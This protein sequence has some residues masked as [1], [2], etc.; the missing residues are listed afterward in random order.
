MTNRSV[1][2]TVS[3]TGIYGIISVLAVSGCALLAVSL[4]D[5][6]L[7][8]AKFDRFFVG[9][10][11]DLQMM[12]AEYRLAIIGGIYVGISGLLWRWRYAF[13]RTVTGEFGRLVAAVR[14]A[15]RAF[16]HESGPHRIA[17]TFVIVGGV[18]LRISYLNM[19]MRLDE[20]RTFIAYVSHPLYIGLSTYYEPN[21]HVF[22]TFLGHLSISLLGNS[23]WGLRVPAFVAGAILLPLAYLF[24][25][26][27]FGKHVGLLC[28][29]L[30]SLSHALIEYSV[31]A[32]GYSILCVITLLAMIVLVCEHCCGKRP[33]F[34]FLSVATALGLYTVPTMVYLVFPLCW[35]SFFSSRF[36]NDPVGWRD[37]Y[38]VAVGYLTLTGILTII[39]YS[40]IFL[41]CGL[42][43]LTANEWVVPLSTPEFV[44]A[45]PLWIE[46][47]W[48]TV[49]WG[50][51]KPISI[52]SLLSCA[53][54]V[55]FMNRQLK[56][57]SLSVTPLIVSLLVL[58][59][60]Q[61][62]TPNPRSLLYLL[63]LYYCLSAAGIYHAIRWIADEPRCNRIVAVVAVSLFIT[64]GIRAITSDDVRHVNR[65]NGMDHVLPH[66]RQ[67]AEDLQAALGSGDYVYSTV[68]RDVVLHYY[69]EVLG[70]FG[71]WYKAGTTFDR[72][73][74]I[75]ES[76]TDLTTELARIGVVQRVDIR[77]LSSDNGTSVYE[78]T[79]FR[80][81]QAR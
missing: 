35:W 60:V 80:E 72:L 24:G 19:P 51:P 5:Q 65:L 3:W 62:V 21:N 29:C 78:V 25:R 2:T 69:L 45:I 6:D 22:H 46:T 13:Q 55:L 9:A 48:V 56:R 54:A 74:V 49:S 47:C 79:A 57:C 26:L 50:F 59:C 70:I 7:A 27:V 14:Q 76:S 4:L 1:V 11:Q 73:F 75:I 33:L 64:L 61:H 10:R 52:L 43:S 71:Y 38:I 18:L 23:E 12:D 36:Q 53:I 8:R 68:P 37:A 42:R 28:L 81:N 39:L 17:V 31:N 44:A 32:R 67:I 63:P 58:V 41:F 40:P 30:V 15:S 77:L 34:V 20:A 66:A 16:H